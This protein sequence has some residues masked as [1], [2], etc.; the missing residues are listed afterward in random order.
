MKKA[1]I[2]NVVSIL[3][4]V[5]ADILLVIAIFPLVCD[6]KRMEIYYWLFIIIYLISILYL[7][8]FRK[9]SSRN[10]KYAIVALVIVVNIIAIG[11]RTSALIRSRL[12]TLGIEHY[13]IEYF[14]SNSVNMHSIPNYK[15]E[16]AKYRTPLLTTVEELKEDFSF[17]GNRDPVSVKSMSVELE[18]DVEVWAY[19]SVYRNYKADS[20]EFVYN[21]LD[22]DA[23]AM[24]VD[25][26][27]KT[28]KVYPSSVGETDIVVLTIVPIKQ[29]ER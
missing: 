18:D 4:I 20:I 3:L 21:E 17:D 7:C 1:C 2:K 14:S 27:F 10:K 13:E 28:L 22:V 8:L 15:L 11:F 6:Y 5:V 24:V 25:T 12:E 9:Y 29:F 26:D 23:D 19:V 16:I